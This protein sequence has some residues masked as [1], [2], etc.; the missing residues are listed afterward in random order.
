[1]M[2]KIF[3]LCVCLFVTFYQG[4]DAGAQEAP[5]PDQHFVLSGAD[6]L[7][8]NAQSLINLIRSSDGKRLVM[9]DGATDAL[10][11][12]KPQNAP[13]PWN[14]GLPSW[15]GTAPGDS[16]GFRVS[17]RIPYMSGWS[18]WL[19]VG[20]WKDDFWPTVKRTAFGGGI[21]DIDFLQLNE[22]ATTWQCA[23][24]FKRKNASV[25][26]PTLSRI[27]FFASDSRTTET[28]NHAALLAD[29]PA[30][31]FIST[32]FLAQRDVSAE[33]GGR[34]CSPSTVAM[35]LKSYH[36]QVDPLQFALDTYDPYYDIFGGWPRVVQN[37]SEYGVIGDVVRI[38]SWSQARDVLARGGRLA[39]SIGAPLYGGHLVMLAGFTANGDP[40]VHDPARPSDGYGHV[41]NKSDLSHAWFDKGGVAYC[42]FQ[43]FSSSTL[44]A[45]LPH[46]ELPSGLRLLQNY[47]NPFNAVTN[48]VFETDKAGFVEFTISDVTGRQVATLFSGHQPAG[49][50]QLRWEAKDAAGLSIAGGMYLYQVRLEDKEVKNG[51]L[52]LIK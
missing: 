25:S 47:P 29:K 12:F 48:F 38:R 52:L 51:R 11:I 34:I 30:A 8:A 33:F 36:I 5:Y 23:V 28:V 20:Y 3:P 32:T 15:N 16:G 7:L 1:M 18:T 44:A 50:H 45:G 6:S 13:Y 10:I 27:S 40:I 19:D 37:A 22:Y 49:T 35:I 14:L 24:Q 17:V 2:K 21:V 39:M 46:R 31:V 41:F 4:R 26:S 42:F 43:D 9:A